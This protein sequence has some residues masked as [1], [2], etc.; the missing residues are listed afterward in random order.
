MKEI[1]RKNLLSWKELFKKTQNLYV[2]LPSV[3]M[4]TC[5]SAAPV[6]FG[7]QSEEVPYKADYVN[8]LEKKTQKGK[9][10]VFF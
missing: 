2:A 3:V 5:R 9:L 1:S 8:I 4:I 10:S 7:R 6:I